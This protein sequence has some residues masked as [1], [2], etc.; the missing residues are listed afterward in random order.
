MA[1]TELYLFLNCNQSLYLAAVYPMI[2]NDRQY[3]FVKWKMHPQLNGKE[4][5]LQ[6]ANDNITRSFFSLEHL[7]MNHSSPVHT[8][9]PGNRL[10]YT[11]RSPA[12]RC[13]PSGCSDLDHTPKPNK[14]VK[15]TRINPGYHLHSFG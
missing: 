7:V 15:C 9:L 2:Q 8:V 3:S 4:I 6:G 12:R 11:V 14:C 10:I 5:F 13:P 1:V